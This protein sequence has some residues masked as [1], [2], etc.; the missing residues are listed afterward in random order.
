MDYLNK[1]I[2]YTVD[3]LKIIG[4]NIKEIK[5]KM[6]MVEKQKSYETL[7]H[8]T[9]SCVP[10][11]VRLEDV[12]ES[13]NVMNPYDIKQN[14]VNNYHQ[15]NNEKNNDHQPNNEKNNDHQPNNEKNK[16]WNKKTF[17]HLPSP[18]QEDDKYKETEQFIQESI[19]DFF[20]P[21]IQKEPFQ[22]KKQIESKCK[23]KSNDN[24]NNVNVKR[25][26]NN[27]TNK[28]NNQTENKNQTE[29]SIVNLLENHIKTYYQDKY[30]FFYK[31]FNM[32]DMPDYKSFSGMKECV[33]WILNKFYLFIFILDILFIEIFALP[34]R[35]LK[36]GF[37]Y[38]SKL[39]CNALTNDPLITDDQKEQ[40]ATIITNL[41]NCILLYPL[42]I[43]ISYNLYYIIAFYEGINN[44]GEPQPGKRPAVDEKRWKLNFDELPYVINDTLIKLLKFL[45]SAAIIPAYYMDKF[46]LGDKW[47]PYYLKEYF[48]YDLTIPLNI[49]K[50]L[51][52]L[53]ITIY[54]VYYTDIISIFSGKTSNGGI[55]SY[56][57]YFCT[58]I[59]I[60]FQ[61]YRFYTEFEINFFNVS[62]WGHYISLIYGGLGTV[63]W[64]FLYAGILVVFGTL[65]FNI[66]LNICILYLLFHCI[67]GIMI[68]KEDS[69]ITSVIKLIEKD[70]DEEI[71]QFYA[72]DYCVGA[73]YFTIV[74]RNIL[75]LV[76]CNKFLIVLSGLLIYMFSTQ[77][78]SIH[79]SILK[80]TLF[81][82][83]ALP[84]I[85]FIVFVLGILIYNISRTDIEDTPDMTMYSIFHFI[86]SIIVFLM[87]LYKQFEFI[88]QMIGLILFGLF[89]IL[90]LYFIVKLFI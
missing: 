37:H 40:D 51:L 1:D 75:K 54:L 80:W 3:K 19:Y 65:S 17:I 79:S 35:L 58:F 90:F 69:T 20:L 89:V 12:E 28:N 68:Y 53:I 49:I 81:F 32:D 25:K 42:V 66:A 18:I 71:K 15:P 45:F 11:I 85:F 47:L 76:R 24:D 9:N 73:S 70:F 50:H 7:L 43:F 74:F 77:I 8:G 27:D 86:P 44:E 62:K 36:T 2:E 10:P 60:V 55:S 63:F 34:V 5:Q 22:E 26:S 67:F 72:G 41:M 83:I 21:T 59:I 78:Y 84:C 38:I 52:L 30:P 29:N 4:E 16:P 6:K 33:R 23:S 31:L 61:L 14:N 56:L 48:V 64:F 46:L 87:S 39:I 82:I 57:L 88:F 13:M